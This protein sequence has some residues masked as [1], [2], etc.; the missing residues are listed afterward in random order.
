MLEVQA[1]QQLKHL[2]RGA[3]GHWEHQLTLSRLVGRSLRRHDRTKIHLS[4]G[5][6][7]RWWLALLVPLSLQSRHTVLVLDTTQHQRLLH[8][9]RPRLLESGLR[10]G[11]WTGCQPPPGDQ[12]WLLTPQQ[13]LT[14]HNAGQ[15]RPEDHLVIPEAEWLP[16]RLR[17]AMEVTIETGHWEE[18]RSA[19][20]SAGRA[21]L[22]LHERL[23]RQLVALGGGTNRDLAMPASALTV[24]RDL[25]QLLGPTPS[26]WDQLVAMDQPSWASWARMDAQTLQWSWHFQPLEPLQTLGS[27]FSAHPWTLIH[28][29]GGCRRHGEDQ[30]N[31]SEEL[32]IDL[33]DAPRGEAIPIYLPRRQPLPN[34][35]IYADHLLE[36]SRRLILGRAGLTAVLV[37]APGIRHRLC[38]ELA[39]EFGSRVT[40]EIT[41]PESNGVICCS[42]TWWLSHQHLLPEPDQ[43]IAAML[44]IASL[45]NPLTAARV[46]ALKRQGRDWFRT[47]LL[48]EA[49]AILIPAITSLRR[50]GGRLAILDGRVRARSWGEQ[51]LRALEPW[52]PLQR[53]LP[54]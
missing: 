15:L 23:N 31:S 30:N 9:E 40:L 12:L 25:L 48:P 18:L 45:E 34:T 1:H 51:V 33:R 6:S 4:A 16:S 27:L 20:P 24:V 22:E 50:S 38:S 19:F 54:D 53:L 5:S 11:C 43:L 7:D 39:A 35:E 2:L 32:R 46:D 49:L 29:D 21:L 17:R 41:A 44:P 47:L 3:S 28:A 36:Q 26:P 13:L 37:D 8:V 10:L 14:V 52:T 42:W